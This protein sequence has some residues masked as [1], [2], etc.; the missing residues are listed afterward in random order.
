MNDPCCSSCQ[1]ALVPGELA[2]GACG[3]PCDPDVAAGFALRRQVTR[4]DTI[5]IDYD[6]VDSRGAPIDT[7]DPGVRIWFTIKYYLRDPDQQALVQATLLNGG[8]VARD[9]AQSGRVRVTIAASTTV[10]IADGIAKLYYDL[11]VK[12]SAG[13]VGTVEKGLFLVSPDVSRATT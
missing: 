3:S 4:G 12:D 10:F 6:L 5:E 2:C 8:I 1:N 13:R 7:S 9:S 11:Q